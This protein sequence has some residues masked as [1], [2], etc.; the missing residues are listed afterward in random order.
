MTGTVVRAQSLAWLEVSINSIHVSRNAGK[1]HPPRGRSSVPSHLGG[2][3]LP[4]RK[5]GSQGGFFTCATEEVRDIS[6]SVVSGATEIFA[7]PSKVEE[8]LAEQRVAD[9]WRAFMSQ[10][11]TGAFPPRNVVDD[12]IRSK[13]HVQ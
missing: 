12:L 11:S 9:A 6:T 4:T 2:G 13:I 8:L 5:Q 1:S 10:A 7:A 3:M